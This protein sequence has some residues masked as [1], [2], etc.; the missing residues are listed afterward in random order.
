MSVAT[1]D[2]ALVGMEADAVEAGIQLW[3]GRGCADTATSRWL[4]AVLL[5]LLGKTA[6]QRKF[7]AVWLDGPVALYVLWAYTVG[8]RFEALTCF[9]CN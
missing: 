6:K 7:S 8:V 5:H 1:G 4:Q 2:V 9:F 3:L